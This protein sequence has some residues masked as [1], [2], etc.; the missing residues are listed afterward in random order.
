MEKHRNRTRNSMF[1]GVPEQPSKP[2]DTSP[3]TRPELLSGLQQVG[4]VGFRPQ[5]LRSMP[6]MCAFS[7]VPRRWAVCG[8][9]RHSCSFS[10]AVSVYRPT[11]LCVLCN[12]NMHQAAGQACPAP[13]FERL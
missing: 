9:W 1:E 12:A 3:N 7:G 10:V 2:W 8:A 11:P 13:A 5:I 6:C 4:L